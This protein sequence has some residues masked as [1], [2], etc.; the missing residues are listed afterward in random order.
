METCRN[1]TLIKDYSFMKNIKSAYEV[2]WPNGELEENFTFSTVH[3]DGVFQ[4]KFRWFNGRW[5]GWCTL[6]S[7]EIRAFGVEPLVASWV[8]FL[9]YGITFNTELS[10]IDKDSLFNTRLFILSW[11]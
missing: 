9:D 10:V 11:E 3:P 7:G 1:T 4:F 5:N 2:S 8:G 6:P